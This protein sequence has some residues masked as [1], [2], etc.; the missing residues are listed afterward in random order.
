MQKLVNYGF[1]KL[2]EDEYHMISTA[3]KQILLIF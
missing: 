2:Q 3:L 1:Y